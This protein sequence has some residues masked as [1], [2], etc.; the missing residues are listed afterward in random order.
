MVSRKKVSK[1]VN[2]ITAWGIAE[3]SVTPAPTEP[4]CE[5]MALKSYADDRIDPFARDDEDDLIGGDTKTIKQEEGKF[6]LYSSDGKKKLGTHDS[7]AEAIAQ[8]VAIN[9]AKRTIVSKSISQ[10]SEEPIV[11]AFK[12]MFEEKLREKVPSIWEIRSTLDDVYRDIAA[13][14]LTSNITEVTIDVEAKCLEAAQEEAALEAPLAAKQIRAWVEKG[15]SGREGERFYI[16]SI[17]PS[18]IKGIEGVLEPGTTINAHSEMV[19]SA[20]EEFVT[21][22]KAINTGVETYVGRID[23]RIEFRANDPLKA[24]RVLSADTLSKLEAIKQALIPL[25]E[26]LNGSNGKI[27]EL[28]Q[29]ATPKSKEEK[30]VADETLLLL[31]LDFTRH[32]TEAAMIDNA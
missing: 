17:H 30:S 20:L 8:E 23:Q 32:Q 21:V 22:V 16:R 5:A 6:V 11:N 3:G 29:K 7:K 19:V 9:K 13:A 15:C 24:G 14:L 10:S 26:G 4:R 25:L 1:S 2:E 18:A 12:G 28:I 31:Q 27:D